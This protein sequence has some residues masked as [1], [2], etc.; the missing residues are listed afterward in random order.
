MK[1]TLKDFAREMDCHPNTVRKWVKRL[2]C[3]PDIIG[4]GANKWHEATARKF[5]KAW[6]DFYRQ[7]GTT[8]PITRAKYAGDW[9]DT[10]QLQLF[11]IFHVKKP[12]PQVGILPERMG[13][14]IARRKEG[15][16]AP[17]APHAQKASTS[18]RRNAPAR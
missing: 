18:R 7:R 13:K 16:D 11:P 4:H 14:T 3:P 6:N 15:S 9:F 12:S 1:W 2:A 10:R 8:L 5:L 17:A